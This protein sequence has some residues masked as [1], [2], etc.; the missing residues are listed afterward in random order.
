MN[1]YSTSS[2]YAVWRL[3]V[4]PQYHTGSQVKI[5]TWLNRQHPSSGAIG[6]LEIAMFRSWMNLS[7]TWENMRSPLIRNYGTGQLLYFSLGFFIV[8]ELFFVFWSTRYIYN[9]G[10]LNTLFHLIISTTITDKSKYFMEWTFYHIKILFKSVFYWLH[11]HRWLSTLLYHWAKE[12][13]I[14]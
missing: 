8:C 11:C 9:T 7:E 5:T 10:L 6:F 14:Y 1:L 2:F 3:G 4:V 12:L 13:K